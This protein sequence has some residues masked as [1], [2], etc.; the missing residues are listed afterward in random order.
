MTT[1]Y[2]LTVSVG[3]ESGSRLAEWLKLRVPCEAVVKLL[4]RAEVS[5]PPTQGFLMQN[6]DHCPNLVFFSQHC[7]APS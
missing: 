4:T 2:P 5:L 3:Q 7:E 6:Y 1:L